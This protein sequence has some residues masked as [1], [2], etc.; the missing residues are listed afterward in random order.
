MQEKSADTAE[1]TDAEQPAISCQPSDLL[2]LP[3]TDNASNQNA[4]QISLQQSAAISTIDF[5]QSND[6]ITERPQPVHAKPMIETSAHETTITK[7]ITDDMDLD[8]E[9][10]SDGELEEEARIRGLGDAL[11][12][13]WASLVEESR[14]IAREKSNVR[15]T[16]A[17]Q[18]WKP[19][20]ILLDVGISLKMAGTKF[21]TDMLR[22]VYAKLEEEE[23][24]EKITNNDDG[25]TKL[26][27]KKIKL[28]D[29][30]EINEMSV[31]V[32]KEIST[33]DEDGD[34]DVKEEEQKPID[35][36]SVKTEPSTSIDMNYHP[37]ASVQVAHRANIE[38]RR[39][40]VFNA[41]GPYSRALSTRRDLQMRRQLCG[42]SMMP[43]RK[44]STNATKS[45]TASQ[46]EISYRNLALELFQKA[47]GKVR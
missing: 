28:E 25:D 46:K 45:E 22:N 33:E 36:K 11:G 14:A 6:I 29:D 38:R 43:I 34:C 44:C 16:S 7:D 41:T 18:R 27:K 39:G 30:S 8:F 2:Q 17:K 37:I 5:I 10:I 21:G 26:D 32:K 13:D 9:E 42:Q 23:I 19:H 47:M 31:E 15:N 12:V 3:E 24:I 4:S 35:V 20:R 40:L 1:S